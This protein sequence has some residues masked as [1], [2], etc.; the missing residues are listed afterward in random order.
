[1]Y[2]KVFSQRVSFSHCKSVSL[3]QIFGKTIKFIS[4]SHCVKR[5][6]IRSFSGPYFPAFGLNTDRYSD[7]SV[8]SP[9]TGKYGPEN[10]RTRKFFTQC[11]CYWES[12]QTFFKLTHF[13]T[14]YHERN[15]L[16]KKSLRFPT[17]TSQSNCHIDL[18]EDFHLIK[19]L[20]K[21]FCI[22]LK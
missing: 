13:I 14:I 3:D 6:R 9:N 20:S 1:M 5:V 15:Q 18:E 2:I 7:L 19:F 21:C 4:Y 10:F 8:V 16:V 17:N 11:Q 22:Q 12:I